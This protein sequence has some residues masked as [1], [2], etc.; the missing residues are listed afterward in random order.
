MA[1]IKEKIPRFFLLLAG[2]IITAHMIIPH[3]HHLAGIIPGG[4]ETCPVSKDNKRPH[5]GFPIHCHAFND[6]NAE[7]ATTFILPG[8]VHISYDRIAH[9]PDPLV[10]ELQVVFT[11]NF[12]V[13]RTIPDFSLTETCL[14]RAP[15]SFTI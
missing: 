10:I 7:E 4:D 13:Q 11:R 2:L 6:I 5:N 15:P 1:G 14:L 12:D 9:F 3:D 8:N